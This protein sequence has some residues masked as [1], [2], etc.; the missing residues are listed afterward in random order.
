[1]GAA[2]SNY[3]PPTIGSN[4]DDNAD[5]NEQKSSPTS[6]SSSSPNKKQRTTTKS[7][8]KGHNGGGGSGGGIPAGTNGHV[9]VPWF[10]TMFTKDDEQYFQY[11]A[12]EWGF[13]KVSLCFVCVCV[14]L[15]TQ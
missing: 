5:T 1:M 13:E 12:N 8:T 4:G 11:M 7:S 3:E 15:Q 6:L 9:A 10:K 2:D 14:C